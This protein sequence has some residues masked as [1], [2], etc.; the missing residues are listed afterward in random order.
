[1]PHA[2]RHS[3]AQFLPPHGRVAEATETRVPAAKI[4]AANMPAFLRVIVRLF[5]PDFARASPR[6][7]SARI[8]SRNPSA[9]GEAPP[10]K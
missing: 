3:S 6:T 1:V 7:V 10:D 4:A 9:A 2:L 8:R 5:P